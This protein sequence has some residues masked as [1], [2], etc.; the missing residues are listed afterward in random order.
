[1]RAFNGERLKEARYFNSLSI[2][3]LAKKLEVSKQMVSKYEN[4]KSIPSAEIL[5]KI[6]G[7]LGFPSEF[8]FQQDKFKETSMGTF[9]RSRLTS[10]QKQKT[11]SES[12]KRAVA[13]YRDY[14]EQ[15]I[16]FPELLRPSI[17][18][19][20][21][22]IEERK[23]EKLSQKLRDYW[24]LG[25]EP[26]RDMMRLLEEKG[27]VNAFLPKE[28]SKVD[29]FG[30]HEFIN[31]KDYYVILSRDDYSFYR[32]QFSLAHE[33]GHWFIH[34]D[35]IN[36]QELDAVE[37]REKEN[38]ANNFASSFLLPKDAFL[39]DLKSAK[40][41]NLT[42]LASLKGKW[43]VAIGAMLMRAYKLNAIT[44]EQY[45][46]MQKQISYQGWRKVEPMDTEKM[47]T[48]PVAL[49]QATELI[50]DHNIIRANDIPT[51]INQSYGRLYSS[52]FLEKIAN[53][54][55]SYLNKKESKVI[56]LKNKLDT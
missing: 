52:S 23:Y 6:I 34:T 48:S 38:E 24:D 42:L 25:Q 35:N 1:M 8:Y 41:V 56:K 11:P 16:D 43:N 17:P 26:I 31:S 46:K 18:D 2:T 7:L 39:Y 47:V 4:D 15:Y 14:L 55:E 21:L 19:F 44:D 49:K 40:T 9:Y 32:Q 54:D 27:F 13:L 22:L 36:P 53:L 20:D 30:S 51:L 37:Y 45:L 28:M 10:T 50:V 12:I 3:E 33:L 29:A 5:F